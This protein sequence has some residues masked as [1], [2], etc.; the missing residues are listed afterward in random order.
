MTTLRYN[1]DSSARAVITEAGVPATTESSSE[2]TFWE[3][4]AT[5]RWGNYVTEVERRTVLRGQSLAGRPG[6]ALEIGC[7][8]GRWSKLLSDQGWEMT[9]IDV[10]RE[11]LEECRRKVPSARCIL[12]DPRDETIPCEPSSSALLLCIEV[13]PVIQSEWFLPEVCRVLSDGGVLVGV[14]WNR[15]SWRGIS[16]R[17]KCRL[18]YRPNANEQYY[19]RSYVAWKRKLG[20]AGFR[21]VYEEGFCWGPFS[22]TSNSFLIPTF[23]GLEKLLRLNRIPTLSPWIA[24]IAQKVAGT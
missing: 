13:G 22:R 14:F 23:A 21:P 6:R 5:T 11:V 3:R 10:N 12:A 2:M 19:T 15:M 24:F 18:G 7:D 9:C 1:R 17:V 4:V 20:R 8:G 16:H